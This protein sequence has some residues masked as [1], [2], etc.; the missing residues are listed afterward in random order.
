MFLFLISLILKLDLS[1][2]RVWYLLLDGCLVVEVLLWTVEAVLEWHFF[3]K[4]VIM[5][6]AG[7]SVQDDPGAF[8]GSLPQPWD[9]IDG[10]IAD[11][12]GASLE[13]GVDHG[14]LVRLYSGLFLQRAIFASVCLV[15]YGFFFFLLLLLTMPPREAD[16]KQQLDD[17]PSKRTRFRLL[18]THL[19]AVAFLDLLAWRC[20][21]GPCGDNPLAGG[22]ASAE[23][24]EALVYGAENTVDLIVEARRKA[25]MVEQKA[26]TSKWQLL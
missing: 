1:V 9:T 2:T 21:D 5:D 14:L 15:V 4:V 26:C 8:G 11:R 24:D 25:V 22:E 7:H 3:Y 20:A 6:F 12:G 13:R 23:A 19:R 18:P 17:L 10:D 16:L